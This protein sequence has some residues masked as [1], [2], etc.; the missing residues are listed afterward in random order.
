M[1]KKY[2]INILILVIIINMGFIFIDKYQNKS[3]ASHNDPTIIYVST[4]GNDNNDGSIDK[5][6]LTLSKAA[7]VA[8]SNSIIYIREGKYVVIDTIEIN[9]KENISILP[10]N[11]EN[12]I[13]T[14]VHE[15]DITPYILGKTNNQL[16]D[17]KIINNENGDI[18]CIDFKAYIEYAKTNESESLYNFLQ[19]EGND[20]YIYNKFNEIN[21]I[22][23]YSGDNRINVARYPNDDKYLLIDKIF[24]TKEVKN[25]FYEQ[26]INNKNWN[27]DFNKNIYVHGFFKHDWEA[28]YSKASFEQN[29]LSGLT[30]VT[31][32]DTSI[33]KYHDI[34]LGQ[35]VAF[36]NI[37][38]E[39]DTK[40]EYYFDFDT[41]MLYI[42][43][44]SIIDNK[45]S[46]TFKY[47]EIK[48]NDEEEKRNKTVFF[49]EDVE[50]IKISNLNF[51]KIFTHVIYG[52]PKYKYEYENGN[53]YRVI[54]NGKEN[55][56]NIIEGNKFTNIG[57]TSVLFYDTEYNIIRNNIFKN[58]SNSAINLAE[59]STYLVRGISQNNVITNNIIENFD[60]DVNLKPAIRIYGMGNKVSHN[61]ISNGNS[62]GIKISGS[63]HVIEY[64]EIY[65]VVRASG[66]SSAIYFC[67]DLRHIENIV[68][69]NYIHDIYGRIREL[70]CDNELEEL[71]Y[72]SPKSLKE[73]YTSVEDFKNKVTYSGVYAVYIDDL[74]SYTTV[75]NNVLYNLAMMCNVNGGSYNSIKNNILINVKRGI[76]INRVSSNVDN[77]TNA[78]KSFINYPLYKQEGYEEWAK[79]FPNHYD[80]LFSKAKE[81]IL[82]TS[83]ESIDEIL[84]LFKK[85]VKTTRSIEIENNLVFSEEQLDNNILKDSKSCY[86]YI[87]EN[88]DNSYLAYNSFQANEKNFNEIDYE[89]CNIK[90]LD[91]KYEYIVYKT[92]YVRDKAT[93]FGLQNAYVSDKDIFTDFD[94]EDFNIDIEKIK[95]Y[96]PEFT[97]IKFYKIGKDKAIS[98]TFNIDKIKNT[99]I[100]NSEQIDLK[101][102]EI[103]IEYSNG[104]KETIS[105]D[106]AQI[107]GFDNSKPGTI[108]ITAK[109]L[110][111]KIDFPVE[112][113]ANELDNSEPEWEYIITQQDGV[114]YIENIFENHTI[115]EI[116][117]NISIEGDKEVYKDEQKVED[118][119][120]KL[121]TGMVLK[122][123]VD[124][125]TVEYHIVITGDITG[126][127]EVDAKDLLMLARY[128]AGFEEEKEKIKNAYLRATDVIKDG[129][130]ASNADLLKLSRVLANLEELE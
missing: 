34:A 74:V 104:S 84:D 38:E 110:G 92:S 64:N 70:T 23:L 49:L 81:I 44:D 114:N 53:P 3:Y 98:I 31:L 113:I 101:D 56:S 15:F 71:Y 29:A 24:E 109:Y 47:K 35:R 108:N 46:F 45:I 100:Q 50:N 65:D 116:K 19:I 77:M 39:L 124:D 83:S 48:N 8:P 67:G 95:E 40:N 58:V 79:D 12:V 25:Y 9:G 41:K 14:T 6:Y 52:Q 103:N 112:I 5:P 125:E 120:T 36:Y 130:F 43:K 128:K 16:I 119:N 123:T 51:D 85:Y 55:K 68:Q 33:I 99:Y 102:G 61:Q 107:E 106:R 126:D 121:A 28:D 60:I 4:K 7:N 54:R 115:E 18:I 62:I 82:G 97:N 1:N 59:E 89:S 86:E 129:N 93:Y 127:G 26:N 94:N 76:N 21:S 42:H 30:K 57:G 118:E 72:N 10:Y 63:K 66:D 96:L 88:K 73:E 13:I 69:Y 91:S 22:N 80:G 11:N 27:Y 20:E 87:V 117:Q 75:E 122:V 37:F 78:V 17:G 2:I 111:E 105:M 32:K 90:Y